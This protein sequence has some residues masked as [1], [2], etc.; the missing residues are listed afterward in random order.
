MARILI[1]LICFYSLF[2][3]SSCKKDETSQKP[4]CKITAPANNSI[5]P[6]C[7][8]LS[9]YIISEDIDG[10]I[11]E[12][13][14]SV[15]N[16]IKHVET[17][18]PE[19]FEWS[20]NTNNLSIGSHTIKA[21]AKDS[22]GQEYSDEININVL[23]NPPP[24]ADFS[25]NKTNITI[26]EPVEFTDLTVNNPTNWL[27]DFGD[28]TTSE[29]QNPEHEYSSFGEYTVTLTASNACGTDI[30]TT[31]NLIKVE[32]IMSIPCPNCPTVT[33]ADGN[34]YNT[35]QI[36]NFCWMAENLK[37]G[38][39]INSS[40]NQTNNGIIEKYCYEDDEANC[41]IYGGLYQWDEMMQYAPSDNGNN[42]TTQG[43]C[44]EGWHIPT[45]FEWYILYQYLGENYDGAGGKL[46]ETGTLHWISP[47]SG[48]TNESG[49]A[50]LP[51]GKYIPG[52]GFSMKGERGQ[53]FTSEESSNS[54]LNAITY[55]LSNTNDAVGNSWPTKT[56]A[57]SV[58][59][60]KYNPIEN[61]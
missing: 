20:L 14:I 21:S 54:A 38:T 35:V 11:V 45:D 8:L 17:G 48:A 42:G 60:V 2:F 15:D 31:S 7:T 61:K 57:L 3:L 36:G 12:V 16:S 50:A 33:D 52:Q 44:P 22:D 27:W 30:I 56:T 46:K 18:N 29:Q 28:N 55:F 34:V 32:R 47:N 13:K 53:F 26:W 25:V 24:Q 4:T 58:R 9:I 51:G 41:D 39:T 10:Q 5:I 49:F 23:E 19:N 40:V 37:V 43:I 59:C 6:A 1:I